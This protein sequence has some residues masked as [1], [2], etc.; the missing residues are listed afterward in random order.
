MDGHAQV[1]L[2]SQ[3]LASLEDTDPSKSLRTHVL[4]SLGGAPA[5]RMK[6][7]PPPP[8]SVLPP[9]PPRRRLNA[10]VYDGIASIFEARCCEL[11]AWDEAG[12]TTVAQ[13]AAR[14]PALAGRARAPPPPRH[15]PSPSLARFVEKFFADGY[16]L[17]AVARARL[18]ACAPRRRARAPT[19]IRRG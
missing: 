5:P 18:D 2:L 1:A 7:R 3:I 11:V 19:R 6:T 9:P 15:A 14:A 13:H 17:E 10:Q 16:G 12:R 4:T 8:S